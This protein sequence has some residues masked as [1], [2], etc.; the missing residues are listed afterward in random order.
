MSEPSFGYVSVVDSDFEILPCNR[1]AAHEALKTW[2]CMD[3]VKDLILRGWCLTSTL[4]QLGWYINST[5]LEEPKWYKGR[6]LKGQ[7]DTR[8]LLTESGGA[9][10]DPADLFPVLAPY[11][12]PGSWVTNEEYDLD[13]RLYNRWYFFDGRVEKVPAH[14]AFDDPEGFIPRAKTEA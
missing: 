1:I 5:F 13:D 8:T 6:L 14:Y 9:A 7:V 10:L 11:V 4:R 3:W 2:S 12:V